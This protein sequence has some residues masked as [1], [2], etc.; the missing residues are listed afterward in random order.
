MGSLQTRF[1]S[2]LFGEVCWGVSIIPYTPM[3]FMAP[4]DHHVTLVTCLCRSCPYLWDLKS[5][6][7]GLTNTPACLTRKPDHWSP[8]RNMRRKVARLAA[9]DGL[10]GFDQNLSPKADSADFFART[11]APG[12][13]VLP[14][15]PQTS[16]FRGKRPAS[17]NSS[18]TLHSLG[19]EIPRADAAEGAPPGA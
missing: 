11:D 1:F 3:T 19:A 6:W 8:V 18:S 17:L 14:C 2:I 13:S 10:F 4:N 15:L 7:S 9:K 12:R 16:H 5:L